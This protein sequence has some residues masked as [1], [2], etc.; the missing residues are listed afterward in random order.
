MS[1]SALTNAR[2]FFT[3]HCSGCGPNRGTC[4]FWHWKSLSFAVFSQVKMPEYVGASFG[5][6]RP[7]GTL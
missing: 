6:K 3:D 7:S 5:A 1:C 4:P 2:A